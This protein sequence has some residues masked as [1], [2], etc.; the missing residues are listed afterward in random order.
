MKRLS[1]F[2]CERTEP[3]AVLTFSTGEKGSEGDIGSPSWSPDGKRLVYHSGQIDTIPA[4]RRP[5]GL[6][7]GGDAQYELRFASGFPAVSLI[8]MSLSTSS[9]VADTTRT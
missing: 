7:Y 5:G 8:V 4:A 3:L 2:V 6:L 9:R 1:K